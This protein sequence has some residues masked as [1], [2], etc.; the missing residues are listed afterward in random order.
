M[1][2]LLPDSVITVLR[3]TMLALVG[4]IMSVVWALGDFMEVRDLA[5]MV[6]ACI[7]EAAVGS[8]YYFIALGG[9][10]TTA[11]GSGDSEA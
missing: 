3:F 10:S 9:A 1:T 8:L 2:R 6:R 11:S 7:E 4:E 5:A